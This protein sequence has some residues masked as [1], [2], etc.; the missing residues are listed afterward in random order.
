MATQGENDTIDTKALRFVR[1]VGISSMTAAGYKSALSLFDHFLVS[2]L[3]QT[4]LES[5][6]VERLDAE[7]EDILRGYSLWLCDTNI[8]KN[9][10]NPNRENREGATYMAHSG[11]REYLGKT[12]LVLKELLPDNP[13]L[14][15]KDEIDLISGES[16][17]KKVHCVCTTAIDN[18]N[19]R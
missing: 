8:P 13:F 6:H 11:L 5:I 12:I 18:G 10:N 4:K 1:D 15:D 16:F 9:H 17:K 7:V 2:V 14:N 19:T 3:N